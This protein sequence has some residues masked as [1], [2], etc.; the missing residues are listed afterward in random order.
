[1]IGID[2]SSKEVKHAQAKAQTYEL[3]KTH[4]VVADMENIPIADNSVDVIISNGAFCLAPNKEKAFQELFRV[5]KPGGRMSVCTTSTKIDNLEPGVSWPLCMKMFV[6]QKDLEPMCEKIGFVN[7]LVDDSDSSMTMEIPEEVLQTS[8][9]ERNKVH[10]GSSDFKHLE[11]YDM[12]QICARVCVLAFKPFLG[13]IPA[14][15]LFPRSR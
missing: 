3:D 15:D 7:I 4:F 10:V 2:I 14:K 5:L 13:Y 6:S 11:N 1:V 12:D 9:P 8:N